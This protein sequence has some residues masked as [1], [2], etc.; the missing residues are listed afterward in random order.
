MDEYI[1]ALLDLVVFLILS[2]L[3]MALLV[4]WGIIICYVATEIKAV[5]NHYKENKHDTPDSAEAPREDGR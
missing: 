5:Y 3:L 2:L 4:A 1:Y